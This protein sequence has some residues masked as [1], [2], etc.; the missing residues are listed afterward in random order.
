LEGLK[1]TGLRKSF[2]SNMVIDG[3]DFEVERGELCILL[4]PSGCGKSTV[5]RLIAGL[6]QEDEGDIYLGGRRVN[7]LPPRDRDIAMVFQSYALYPHLSAYENMAFPLRVKRLP[8]DQID[9]KV[10]ETAALLGLEGLLGR[11]PS[12]LS[13]GQRQRVAMGRAIVRDPGLFLFDEPLSNLDAKLRA[14]MRVELAGL[15]RKL[16]ATMLYVTHDQVEAMTLGEKIILLEGG[17]LRQVGTPRELYEMPLSLFAASFIGSPQINLLEGRLASEGGLFFRSE[18]FTMEVPP[19]AGVGGHAGEDVTLG[20]RP[21]SLLPGEGP[22]K[23]EI[24]LVEHIGSE[25]IVYVRAGGGARLA[26]RAR[27]DFEGKAG[28]TI[29]LDVDAHGLHFF[30]RGKRIGG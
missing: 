21:E 18:P 20:I 2:G 1:V 10:R 6:E 17:R 24:E 30:R 12:E 28:E 29:S 8:R 19:G 25:S 9:R 4:G 7:D 11:K 26:A 15:H 13:G 22:I 14:A 16:G 23:G 5:L 27:A 3:L